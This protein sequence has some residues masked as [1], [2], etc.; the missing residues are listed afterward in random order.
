MRSL[1][2]SGYTAR[3]CGLSK[4]QLQ[5][6]FMPPCCIWHH[7]FAFSPAIMI[8]IEIYFIIKVIANTQR[9]SDDKI[10]TSQGETMR[11]IN[12]SLDDSNERTKDHIIGAL[13][14]L[15]LFE[16]QPHEQ[17][18]LTGADASQETYG[19]NQIAALHRHGLKQLLQLRY[20]G[21]GIEI[22]RLVQ[23]LLV[24]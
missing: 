22:H 12:S 6:F 8:S 10:L 17:V 21:S 13:S 20:T 2:R 14:S 9:A 24:Q 11:I 23:H 15:I 1:V 5:H 3:V 7:I 16:V 18:V 19:S 4:P